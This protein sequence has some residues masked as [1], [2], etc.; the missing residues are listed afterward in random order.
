[1][2][3]FLTS[4]C[5]CAC[6]FVCGDSSASRPNWMVDAA[7]AT[8]N[9]VINILI[10]SRRLS[11]VRDAL[12]MSLPLMDGLLNR[13]SRSRWRR[14]MSSYAINWSIWVRTIWKIM[15]KIKNSKKKSHTASRNSLK[16]LPSTP[17][18]TADIRYEIEIENENDKN[19]YVITENERNRKRKIFW[20]SVVV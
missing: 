11:R 17:P 12:F 16:H 13:R 10:V 9:L 1:M 15:Q 3:A 6:E 7:A 20:T 2:V 14:T 19:K 18:D 5:V 8:A 4:S